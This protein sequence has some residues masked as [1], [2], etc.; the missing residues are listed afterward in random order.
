MIL[1]AMPVLQTSND[2]QPVF[3]RT[4][5]LAPRRDHSAFRASTGCMAITRQAGRKLATAAATTKMR[6]TAAKLS[7]SKGLIPNNSAQPCDLIENNAAGPRVRFVPGGTPALVVDRSRPGPE[8]LAGR[9]RQVGASVIHVSLFARL[10]WDRSWMPCAPADS[11]Q[12]ARRL[13][14]APPFPQR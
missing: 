5:F 6:R 12:T 8:L 9:R 1:G 14:A 11:P 13:R 2:S 7:G 10:P 4:C 3:R